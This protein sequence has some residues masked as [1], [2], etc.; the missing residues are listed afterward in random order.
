MWQSCAPDPVL[1][2]LVT[3]PGCR[4]ESH[5]KFY[6]APSVTI[7]FGFTLR[8]EPG[9]PHAQGAIVRNRPPCWL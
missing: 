9:T 7:F 8:S 4:N 5:G 1:S 3:T 6:I 2:G